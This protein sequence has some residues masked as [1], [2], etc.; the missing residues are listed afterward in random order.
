MVTSILEE[1][2][3]MCISD[4]RRGLDWWLDLHLQV[5]NTNNCNTVADL[6]TTNHLTLSSHSTFTSLYLVTA[7]H[8]GY[9]SA[10]FSLTNLSNG[11]PSA[12]VSHWLT[13]HTWTI[14]CTAL[15]SLNTTRSFKS[16]SLGADP[17]GTPP[18]SPCLLLCDV[19]AHAYAVGAT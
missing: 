18:A 12:S 7:L 19:T 13:L 10:V 16:Y 11:N 15:N 14:N 17:Q 8:N 2:I 1:H 6:H 3:V 9:F 5:I 4:C